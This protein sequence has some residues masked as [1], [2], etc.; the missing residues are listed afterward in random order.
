M[1]NGGHAFPQSIEGDRGSSTPL[2]GEG[3]TVRDYFAA[4]ALSGLIRN[5]GMMGDPKGSMF[6]G[7]NGVARQAYIVAEAMLKVR[8]EAPIQPHRAG[9]DQEAKEE[10]K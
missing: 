3:L 1:Q 8:R 4:A 9:D 6:G 2:G 10:G 5:A 7:P